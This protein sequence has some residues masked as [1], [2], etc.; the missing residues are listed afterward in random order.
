MRRSRATLLTQLLD[1]GMQER[2]LV[3]VLQSYS[4]CYVVDWCPYVFHL[5]KKLCGFTKIRN[6][7]SLKFSIVNELYCGGYTWQHARQQ[8]QFVRHK[9]PMSRPAHYH[10]F[11][12]V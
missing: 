2:Q 1:Q 5:G 12:R 3:S 6:M 7:D 11:S 10:A 4:S 8:L 9:T